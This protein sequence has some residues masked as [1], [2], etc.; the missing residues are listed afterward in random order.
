MIKLLTN[1][2][3]KECTWCPSHTRLWSITPDQIRERESA[4]FR[5]YPGSLTVNTNARLQARDCDS[6]MVQARLRN[7]RV[8]LFNPLKLFRIMA[9]T[10]GTSERCAKIPLSVSTLISIP[11]CC[12]SQK[13]SI[14]CLGMLGSV[15]H[16]GKKTTFALLRVCVCV[17]IIP[18]P[19][20]SAGTARNWFPRLKYGRCKR[21]RRM[22]EVEE[23]AQF[24]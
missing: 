20:S 3:G 21:C 9:L 15:I 24:Y 13:S 23:R 7:E 5:V 6:Y 14:P 16:P 22:R 12:V 2:A 1:S 4:S 17:R 8:L 18:M 11:L 19:G 10:P